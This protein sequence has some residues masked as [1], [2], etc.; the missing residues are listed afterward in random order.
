MG[1]KTIREAGT[2]L[3]G[4]GAVFWDRLFE[5]GYLLLAGLVTGMAFTDTTMLTYEQVG[6]M[7]TLV[8]WVRL[9][10][11][12]FIGAKLARERSWRI[13]EIVLAALFCGALL[14]SWQRVGRAYIAELALLFVG[15]HG[16]DFKKIARVWLAISA[17]ALAGTMVLALTG[18]IENLVYYR[19]VHRRMAFGILY[20]TD[21]AAHVFFLAAGWAWLR[22]RRIALWEIAA[23]AG[24]GVF[25]LVFCDARNSVICLFLLAAGLLYLKLR[26]REAR[27]R[28]G[29]YEPLRPIQWL[30][31]AS[32]PVL[33]AGM[34]LLSRFY[35]GESGFMSALDRGLSGRL[36]LGHQAFLLYPVRLFGQEVPMVGLGGTT[37]PVAEYFFLDSSYMNILFCFGLVVLLCVL[38]TMVLSALREKRAG[39]WERLGLLAVVAL[40]CMVEHHLL[41]LGYNLFLL[42]PLAATD[43]KQKQ[44]PV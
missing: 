25:C 24:L 6:W 10:L 28:G 20:P 11:L 40:Q 12:L 21:F 23:I 18:V 7:Y 29:A 19:G 15:A 27:K 34:I 37:E 9:A 33:A 41:E 36:A 1:R 35:D 13:G 17:A 4:P 5:Y 8:P 30:L 38:G 3:T 44:T 2:R 31:T 43:E 42:L 39:A 16:I 32:A 14:R 26:R 22:E